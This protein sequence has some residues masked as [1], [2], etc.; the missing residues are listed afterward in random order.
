MDGGEPETV[1]CLKCQHVTLFT[2]YTCTLNMHEV[3]MRYC[4]EKSQPQIYITKAHSTYS[5]RYLLRLSSYLCGCQCSVCVC[6]CVK[7][8]YTGT[9]NLYK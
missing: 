3:N 8:L 5:R 1:I 2:V 9:A 7:E 4:S 6:V